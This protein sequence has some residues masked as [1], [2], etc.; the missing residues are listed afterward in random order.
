M[1]MNAVPNEPDPR[2]GGGEPPT[3]HALDRRLTVLESR[4]DTILPTLATKSDMESLR[5]EF[6]SGFER[7]RTEM[8]KLQNNMLKWMIGISVTMFIGFL[9]ANFAMFNVTRSL[10]LSSKSAP[11]AIER[12]VFLTPAE[13]SLP[14]GIYATVTK[15]GSPWM[16]P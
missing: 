3:N 14:P 2:A 13:R 15:R 6:G 8:F 10:F 9:G 12:G 16:L 5:A 11:P 7:L 1:S 4:F